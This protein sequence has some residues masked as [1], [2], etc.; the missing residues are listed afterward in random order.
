MTAEQLIQ[1][2]MTCVTC[3]KVH[4]PYRAGNATSWAGRDGHP[5]RTRLFQMT[6]CSCGSVIE[7]LRQIAGM[8]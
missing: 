5:Y 7:A 2:A 6:G 4:K 3:G 8:G 1:A